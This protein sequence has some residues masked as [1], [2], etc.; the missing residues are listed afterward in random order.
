MPHEPPAPEDQSDAN[1]HRDVCCRGGPLGLM[2]CSAGGPPA[3]QPASVTPPA[4]PPAKTSP[5]IQASTPLSNRLPTDS[6]PVTGETVPWTLVRIDNEANR[7]YLSAGQ[8][9]CAV[10]SVV[11]LQE[12]ATEIIIAVTGAQSSAPFGSPCTAQKVSL[13]GYVQL[14]G[15]RSADAELWETPNRRLWPFRRHRDRFRSPVATGGP[16]GSSGHVGKRPRA[17]CCQG[18]V[19]GSG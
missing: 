19:S 13:V 3:S 5:A 9:S 16:V 4:G 14:N 1:G 15:A 18:A 12:T 8:V 10:P 6:P 11:H 17:S 7:I 2:S